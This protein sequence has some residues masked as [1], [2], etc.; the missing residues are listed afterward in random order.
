MV[1]NADLSAD[2]RRRFFRIDDNIIF[3][4]KTIP[5]EDLPSRVTRLKEGL[6]DQFTVSSSLAAIGHSMTSQLKRIRGRNPDI[7]DYLS[8]LDE[9]IDMLARAFLAQEQD[10][11]EQPAH[12]VNLSGTG[13]AFRA[14]NELE[15]GAMV[16]LK[17]VLF[18]SFT[19]ILTYGE[20]VRCF[21]DPEGDPEY[22]YDI[23]IDFAFIRED[24]RDLLIKHLMGRQLEQLRDHRDGD[25]ET[26]EEGC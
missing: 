12:E 15:F 26:V 6:P 25:R 23:A 4:Y 21:H 20:V 7:A 2:E 16:E 1:T 14:A 13:M 11:S 19:G 24:D 10:L 22:P 18:P 17:L 9:K 3:R 8:T 5:I